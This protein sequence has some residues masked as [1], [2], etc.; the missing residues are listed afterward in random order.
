MAKWVILNGKICLEERASI[1]I[2]DRGFLFGEGFFTTIRVSE[3]HCELLPLHM[4]RLQSQAEAFGIPHDPLPIPLIEEL[5]AKNQAHQG[6]WRLKIL[7]TLKGDLEYPELGNTIA[8]LNPY[9]DNPEPVRLGLYPYPLESPTAHLKT[10]SYLD[11]TQVKK[12]AL[13]EGFHDAI[14]MSKEGFL[15]ETAFSN[16][17]WIDQ[18]VLYYPHFDLPYLKGVY[19]Q[20][21]LANATL[22]NRGV[23]IS[24]EELPS[25]A[26][27]FTC[28]S[29]SHI[30]SVGSIGDRAFPR[31]FDW[32]REWNVRKISKKGENAFS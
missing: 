13:R 23:K 11:H 16:L 17:F 32:E 31:N 30:R 19:L 22:S 3:G 26:S 5:I 8:T 15:L 1:P 10:L 21:L 14:T 18:N 4:H 28:N 2:T 20:H 25:S 9:T 24:F 6:I 12:Y 7:V 29:L 27:V